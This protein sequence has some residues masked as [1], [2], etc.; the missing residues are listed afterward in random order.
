MASLHVVDNPIEVQNRL[1]EL[2]WAPDDLIEVVHAMVAGRNGCTAN[3]PASAPGYM[4][5]KQ[6]T[7][8][9]REIGLSKGLR[10]VDVEQVPWTLDL[11]RHLR[12]A[13]VN[14]DDATGLRDSVPQNRNKR[15][16]A[17]ERAVEVNAHQ[18][19][20]FPISA[21]DTT[22]QVTKLRALGTVAWYLFVYASEDEVRAELSCP[23]AI[24]G[25]YF[26]D[27]VERIFLSFSGGFD[28]P[29]NGLKDSGSDDF[30]DFD[31]PVSRI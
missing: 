15:G 14:S 17:A 22:E 5:W 24:E 27:F 31:V 3:D 19:Q 7:R 10:A 4:S 28:A 16:P 11:E 26:T 23:V 1:S 6:G 12:F 13:V 2:G 8:R 21:V 29:V 25:G 30:V 9:M 20:L 18:Y